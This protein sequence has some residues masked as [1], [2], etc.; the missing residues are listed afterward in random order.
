MNILFNKYLQDNILCDY[1]ISG[2]TSDEVKNVKR[3]EDISKDP[4]VTS[5][6]TYND[7]GDLIETIE[8]NGFYVRKHYFKYEY[9]DLGNKVHCNYQNIS[10]STF[11]KDKLWEE[12][13]VK[14][15]YNDENKIIYK[16]IDEF[17]RNYKRKY[18][19]YYDINSN[20]ISIREIIDYKKTKRSV[21]FNKLFH[22]NQNNLHTET[23]KLECMDEKYIYSQY[24]SIF[25][26]N[27]ILHYSNDDDFK[28]PFTISLD[29][30]DNTITKRYMGELGKEEINHLYY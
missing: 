8:Y 22:Y 4:L 11:E 29:Y 7:N 23:S 2:I 12:G 3:I 24:K 15:K 6:F 16:E 10:D 14:F 27:K 5:E 13:K 1:D 17:V 18:F 26:E 30:N 28:T 21:E 20:L 19:F 25:N 9:N